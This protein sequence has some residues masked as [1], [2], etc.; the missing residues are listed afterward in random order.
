MFGGLW[1]AFNC[2]ANLISLRHDDNRYDELL[3]A[4]IDLARVQ[5]HDCNEFDPY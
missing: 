5:I 3:I 2:N 1:I 4:M